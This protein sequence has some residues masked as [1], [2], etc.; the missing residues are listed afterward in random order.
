MKSDYGCDTATELSLT[1]ITKVRM[2]YSQ[3]SDCEH[4]C[5]SHLA[6]P[7]HL[8][9]E[10]ARHWQNQNDQILQDGIATIRKANS[11]D[12]QTSALYVSIPKR[13]Y[14]RA[15]EDC[16][17]LDDECGQSNVTEDNVAGDAKA[18]VVKDL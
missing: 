6:P 7:F 1:G 12:V 14:W 4:E 18:A 13:L 16:Q 3:S 15:C 9:S 10:E 17:E 11:A 8:E 5:H 2:T